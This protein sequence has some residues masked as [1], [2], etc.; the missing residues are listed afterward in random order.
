VGTF[1]VRAQIEG[2][3]TADG[4]VC[5]HG[6]NAAAAVPK[7]KDEMWFVGNCGLRLR[8]RAGKFS[9][10]PNVS[11]KCGPIAF[12]GVWARHAREVY[13]HSQEWVMFPDTCPKREPAKRLQRFDGR[14]WYPVGSFLYGR[15]FAGSSTALWHLQAPIGDQSTTGHIY[16]FRNNWWKKLKTPPPLHGYHGLAAYD[17]G[18]W[19][20]GGRFSLPGKRHWLDLGHFDGKKWAQHTIINDDGRPDFIHLEAAPDG[21]AWLAEKAAW[22]VTPKTLTKIDLPKHATLDGIALAKSANEVWLNAMYVPTDVLLR[23][24]GKR[25]TRIEIRAAP[26]LRMRETRRSVVVGAGHTWMF[27]GGRIWQ[28]VPP[29]GKPPK[30]ERLLLD[31]QGRMKIVPMTQRKANSTDAPQPAR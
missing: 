25:Y 27:F 14:R 12:W 2:I 29:G 26:E 31:S 30:A 17:G 11:G 13:A 28:L 5:E 10:A 8:H 7:T 22:R 15:K 6:I 20:L 1:F 4:Y 3:P 23:Y 18:V 16:R 9:Q 21:T 24:D 19:V